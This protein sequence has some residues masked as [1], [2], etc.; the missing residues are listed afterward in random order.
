MFTLKSHY[1]TWNYHAGN[2]LFY[3]CFSRLK[4]A[5]STSNIIFHFFV[6]L[7]QFGQVFPNVPLTTPFQISLPKQPPCLLFL[8]LCRKSLSFL[9]TLRS[10]WKGIPIVHLSNPFQ[11]RLPNNRLVFFFSLDHS[12]SSS[13]LIF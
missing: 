7:G 9:C 4:M 1:F 8:T 5:S 12:I 10:I 11:R 6:L 3:V 13:I 2:P